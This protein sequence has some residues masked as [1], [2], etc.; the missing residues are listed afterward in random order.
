MKKM[1]RLPSAMST[2][3][4]PTAFAALFLSLTPPALAQNRPASAAARPQPA[5]QTPASPQPPGAVELAD[6]PFRLDAIG[7]SV[8][9]PVG[10]VAQSTRAGEA[11]AVQ[12]MPGG[13]NPTW[14]VNL[15][16]PRTSDMQQT[17]ESVAEEVLKQ[18][19]SSVGIV[20]R[21][22]SRDG[23]L[24]ERLVS[25]KGTVIE[26][27]RPLEL[28]GIERDKRRPASRFYV[29]LPRGERETAVV[30]GYTIFQVAPGQFVTFD[31][32]ASEPDFAGARRTYETMV[33]TVRF[34]DTSAV[35]AIR[36]A[37]VE[38][39]V[40]LFGR[41]SPS[42]YEAALA[43]LNDRWQRLANQPDGTS[44]RDADELAYRR[45]RAWKGHR[46]ELD[47]KRPRSAWS[48]AERSE[49]YLVRIEARSLHEGMVIDT[50]GIYYMSLDR[51]E[52]A[53]TLQMAVRDPNRRNP[54]IT[55]EIGARS[56]GSMS[57]TTS[58]TG[59]QN[60]AAKPYVPEQGYVTQVETYLLPHLLVGTAIPGEYG[61]YT[62][63]S[64]TSNV[65]LRRDKLEKNPA[66]WT[67]TSRL[68]EDREP[69]VSTFDPSG[70]LIRTTIRGST[71]WTPTTLQR[72]NELW[73]SKGLPVE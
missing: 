54:A 13:P 22:V 17:A 71:A 72:L 3:W 53:W 4:M 67:L 55:T 58:G 25:T 44:D 40:D 14:L 60:V 64:D 68:N 70:Q 38:M 6:E 18:L 45:T 46:G 61:F 33:G 50:V 36:G 63:Q 11:T 9:L 62:Y 51:S 27:V 49:G 31:L 2:S 47:P 10:A 69:Q 37:A 73:R 34:E 57:V 28:A 8:F 32:T 1:L 15:Q 26:P 23:V 65:R 7:M 5:A 12:I 19:L 41:L 48:A 59:R 56:G 24:V 16:T 30:R 39:G 21:Q 29:R 43:R 66:G 52:E 35:A 20:D 42:D